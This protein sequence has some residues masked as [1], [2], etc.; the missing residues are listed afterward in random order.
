MVEAAV[1]VAVAAVATTKGQMNSL[2][3]W[4]GQK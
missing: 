1:E 3:E 4:L 2:R